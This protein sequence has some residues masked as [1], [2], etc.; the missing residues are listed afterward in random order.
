MDRDELKLTLGS[1]YTSTS[2]STES[3]QLPMLSLPE[4]SSSIPDMVPALAMSDF[5]FEPTSKRLKLDVEKTDIANGDAKKVALTPENSLA[6]VTPAQSAEFE[7][8]QKKKHRF[9]G[10]SSDPSGRWEAYLYNSRRKIYLG[11]WDDEK[12]AAKAHDRAAISIFGR[13]C[14]T[15]NF[16]LSDYGDEVTVLEMLPAEQ[17]I[18]SLRTEAKHRRRLSKLAGKKDL[19]G[20]TH[21]G[22][23]ANDVVDGKSPSAT[24]AFPWQFFPCDKGSNSG[25]IFN[26]SMPS[27]KLPGARNQAGNSANHQAPTSSV[28]L[29]KGA[30][31]LVAPP[32]PLLVGKE[33]KTT[34]H[35]ARKR[36][37]QNG[38]PGMGVLQMAHE[39]FMEG[40]EVQGK[41]SNRGDSGM[42][43][44]AD[45]M[46]HPMLSQHALIHRPT[47]HLATSQPGSWALETKAKK[48]NAATST[49]SVSATHGKPAF[50]HNPRSPFKRVE[51]KPI[52]STCLLSLG[53]F[54]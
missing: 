14:T 31:V 39:P 53:G 50:S 21:N 12:D 49:D 17:V 26:S 16:P 48:C 1:P 52:T 37:L 22:F 8:D 42:P 34:P 25:F 13:Q 32:Q 40:C 6:P 15:I 2:A 5:K 45:S 36:R 10:V 44:I 20:G 19:S 3:R 47:A 41:H 18:F 4:S 54:A 24:G 33:G 30:R 9:S 28:Q 29:Q 7:V 35:H 38:L 23:H 11:N 51:R 46:V 27:Y 43:C